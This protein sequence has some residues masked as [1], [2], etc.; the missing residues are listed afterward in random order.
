[1]TWVEFDPSSFEFVSGSP[2]RYESRPRV[3][4]QFCGDCGA[5]LTY[6]RAYEPDTIDVTACSLDEVD[7]I[8]PEDHVW[9]ARKPSWIKLDDGLPSYPRGRF[10]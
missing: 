8:A 2:A 5:Q 1:M 6:E 9:C 3:I 4:R 7:A 10:D